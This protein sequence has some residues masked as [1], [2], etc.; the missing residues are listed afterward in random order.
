MLVFEWQKLVAVIYIPGYVEVQIGRFPWESSGREG[1]R[2]MQGKNRVVSQSRDV[3]LSA[4]VANSDN[5]PPAWLK[6][7]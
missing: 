4:A 3:S 2:N 6:Q 7:S 1:A 5:Q